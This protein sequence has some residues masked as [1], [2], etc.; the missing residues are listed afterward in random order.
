MTEAKLI[1]EVKRG[2]WV[3]MWKKMIIGI[4]VID[5]GLD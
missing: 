3:E 1:F 5:C 4:S 2:R